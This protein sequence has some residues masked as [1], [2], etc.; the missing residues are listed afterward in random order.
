MLPK[1]AFTA[2]STTEKVASSLYKWVTGN[3]GLKRT[4]AIELKENIELIRLYVESGAD[5]KELVPKI[6]DDA[7][8][9]A[10]AEG[11]NFNSLMRSK[12]GTRST[13]DSPQLKK[14]HDWETQR[15]FENVYQKVATLKQAIAIT[16]SKKTVRIGVR[17]GNVFKLMVM[18]AIHIG[19]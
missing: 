12:I 1:D 15:V 6:N 19:S 14:Y 5:P 8:R 17:L 18:L 9:N 10:L 7:F 11:F 13:K 2:I 16:K 4:V 3:R